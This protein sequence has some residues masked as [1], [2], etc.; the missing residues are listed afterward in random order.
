M[1]AVEMSTEVFYNP[2]FA[3]ANKGGTEETHTQTQSS[4]H[5]PPSQGAVVSR[6]L[7]SG[8]R[9]AS[10]EP[11]SDEDSDGHESDLES[12]KDITMSP[13]SPPQEVA[14][15]MEKEKNNNNDGSGASSMPLA[16]HS[17]IAKL[18]FLYEAYAPQYW[19]WEI[20][21]TYRRLFM[22]AVLS[23]VDP[24]TSTQAVFA[25]LL[26]LFFIKL[27]SIHAPYST[28][29]DGILAEVGQFQI[30]FTFFG[31]LVIQGDLLGSTYNNAVGAVL[32]LLNLCVFLLGGF[33]QYQDT[34]EV[35][36]QSKQLL[37]SIRG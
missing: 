18:A 1:N 34:T 21:E 27:Y 24:G 28:E 17:S 36:A 4:A 25:V 5:V 35:L 7:P 8:I 19:Y 29:S 11:D 32:V 22:T 31:G 33:F 30:F 20:I 14:A 9:K 10:V 16:G 12:D 15:E 3:R 23:V 2:A 13:P 26:A 37:A 6:W